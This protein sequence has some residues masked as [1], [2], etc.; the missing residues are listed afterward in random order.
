MKIDRIYIGGWFQ[1][2]TLHLSELYDF[3]HDGA[4][5]LALDPGDLKRLRG[6]LGLTSL[7][8]KK[9]DLDAI[10]FGTANGL[11]VDVFEDGLLL[12]SDPSSEDPHESIAGLRSFYENEFSEALDYLFSLGAPIP[13]ELADIENIYPYF[14]VTHKARPAEIDELLESFGEEKYFEIK[15]KGFQ[16]YRGD[17]LY[18]VNRTLEK[19]PAIEKFIAEQVFMREFKVQMHRYLNLHRIIWERIEDV[20]ERGSIRGYEI[21]PFRTKVEQYQKTINL[22]ES[23]INQMGLFVRTRKAIAEADSDLDNF[24]EVLSFKYDTLSNSLNYVKEVWRMTKNYVS[25]ALDLFGSLNERATSSSI[26][27]LTVV[28]S[29]GVG[30]SLIRMFTASAPDFTAFGFIYFIILAAIGW[31]SGQLLQKYSLGKVYKVKD[32]RADTDIHWEKG[33]R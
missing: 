10:N 28:T 2:T 33:A 21:G 22:I 13:K 27:N 23:R 15:G 1:R 8:M 32:I 24:R 26:Q 30:A 3:L 9:G 17:K 5:P 29:M 31:G 19:L 12:F 14:V 4:S 11:D 7:S 20:K 18:V 25:S 16:I 6:A